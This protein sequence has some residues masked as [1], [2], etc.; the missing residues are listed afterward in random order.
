MTIPIAEKDIKKA[1]LDRLQWARNRG[2]LWFCRLNAGATL[3]KTPEKRYMVRN[4]PA[5]TA[6]FL[7][8]LPVTI[9]TVTYC[10][11]V[12]CETKASDGAQSPEQ[13]AFQ[14]EVEA[15]GCEYYVIRTLAELEE[16]L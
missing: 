13:I 6:D 10:R 8:I 9:E 12:F 14:R 4:A 11:C 5:G 1:V 3:I 16:A 2:E 7:V 15:L